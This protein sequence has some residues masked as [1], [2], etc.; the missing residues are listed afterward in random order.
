MDE[1]LGELGRVLRKF[2]A[3]DGQLDELNACVVNIDS[4]GQVNRLGRVL[5]EFLI[6]RGHICGLHGIKTDGA[7]KF[8]FSAS[9]DSDFGFEICDWR[10]EHDSVRFGGCGGG[11]GMLARRWL[12]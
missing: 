7:G 8:L 5:F 9:S 6:N 10:S 1:V 2:A 12:Q 4:T 11:I 3:S